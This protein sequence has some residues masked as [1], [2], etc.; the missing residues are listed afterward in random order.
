MTDHSMPGEFTQRLIAQPQQT[1]TQRQSAPL[2]VN[3]ISTAHMLL[4]TELGRLLLANDVPTIDVNPIPE[5][6]AAVRDY[7]LKVAALVDAW[8]L[9]IGKEA[10]ANSL[11]TIDLKWFTETFT[12]AV[13]GWGTSEF[14]G[15]AEALREEHEEVESAVRGGRTA[16]AIIR[17]IQGER[18]L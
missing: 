2:S 4:I 7:S 8:W 16:S 5:D 6:F 12:D 3:P 13:E 15:A 1:E 18:G 17:T 9:A 14:D 10:K 11:S